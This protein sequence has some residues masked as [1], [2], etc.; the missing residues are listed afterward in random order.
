MASDAA[1]DV[2]VC[3]DLDVSAPVRVRA[4]FVN[5]ERCGVAGCG[6]V[7]KEAKPFCPSHLDR[8]PYV[9]SLREQLSRCHDELDAASQE[10]G[11]RCIDPHGVIAQEILDQVAARGAPTP[12]G[13]AQSVGVSPRAIENYIIVLEEAGLVRNVVVKS[14]RGGLRRVVMLEQERQ[15]ILARL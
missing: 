5:R 7:P 11:W 14:K 4:R 6:R 13:L 8:L 2:L 1:F 9:Q 12:Q 3:A 10:D 15:A